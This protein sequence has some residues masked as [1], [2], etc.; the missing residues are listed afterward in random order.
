MRPHHPLFLLALLA[1]CAGKN[2]TDTAADLPDLPT[3]TST[4]TDS[5]DWRALSEMGRVVDWQEAE[6]YALDVSGVQALMGVAGVADTAEAKHGVR[7][8]RVRYT[9]QDR[10]QNTEAT[11]LI[12]VPD[13]PGE[14]V[15]SVLYFHP[16]TGFEDFCAPSGRDLTRA[17]VP[18]VLASMGFAVAAPDY[19]G[20]N[21][22]GE[23]APNLH[24]YLAAEPTAV[25]S[26]DALRAM[27][28]FDSDVEEDILGITPA[29]S[30]VLLG[31]S[32]GG[33]A[34][35]WAERYAAEYLP[36]A[37]LKGTFSSVPLMDLLTWAELGK[38][39]LSV[40]SLGV[41]FSLRTL[42]AWY[43]TDSDITEVI[44]DGQL[45]A[46]DD[47]IATTCPPAELPDDISAL[48]QIYSTE[49]LQTFDADHL[50]DWQPWSCM[51]AENSPQTSPVGRTA[52]VPAF[53]VI[54]GG[55]QVALTAQSHATVAALCEAGH[56]VVAI[57]CAGL[58]HEDTVA[59]TL[60][61]TLNTLRTLADGAPLDGEVCGEIP[62]VDCGG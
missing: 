40:G 7:V 62:V 52:Q 14:V 13:T 47:A 23:E 59:A 32:Q 26:L 28:S 30:T 43:G 24:P 17:G 10:G 15:D 55:D 18:I 29:R 4:C 12:A 9:T 51:L 22:I 56:P 61:L 41:P 45:S 58:D 44:A 27:W 38:E 25:A 34:A 2:D 36:E 42:E 57:E 21:G 20:Q 31:A 54:G 16:T 49:W 11:G 46:L 50:D 5:Y 19:L 35:F 6:E 48:D 33:G 39:S 37:E 1:G 8:Y 3:S 60:D 53:V